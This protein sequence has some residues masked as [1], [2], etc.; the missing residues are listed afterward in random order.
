MAAFSGGTLSYIDLT[1]RKRFVE[2]CG[3]LEGKYGARF[4]PCWVLT[5]LAEKSD[6]FYGRSPPGL[7]SVV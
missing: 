5:D 7:E 3:R 6:T 1:G 2:L 4:A